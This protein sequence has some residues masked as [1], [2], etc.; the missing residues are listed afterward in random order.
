MNGKDEESAIYKKMSKK[1]P[2]LSEESMSIQ[3]PLKSVD[4]LL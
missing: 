3:K 2:S 1:A 4:L